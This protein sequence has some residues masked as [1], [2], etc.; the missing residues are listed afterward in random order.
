EAALE[1]NGKPGGTIAQRL[2]GYEDL[3]RRLGIRYGQAMIVSGP[4]GTQTLQ[5]GP[6][7]AEVKEA[8]AAVE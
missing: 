1:E 4:N 2:E 3:G 8:I 5:E 7:L 6:T